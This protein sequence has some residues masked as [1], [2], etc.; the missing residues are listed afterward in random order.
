MAFSRSD[1]SDALH[2]SGVF[3]RHTTYL[4]YIDTAS[5]ISCLK[6]ST[7]NSI[8]LKQN[9]TSLKK[10]TSGALFSHTPN[11]RAGYSAWEKL[12]G[13]KNTPPNRAQIISEI[14]YFGDA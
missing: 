2:S 12:P 6:K 5:E 11:R 13:C 14:I 9:L 10:Q 7:D 1:N 8:T 3:S 4:S